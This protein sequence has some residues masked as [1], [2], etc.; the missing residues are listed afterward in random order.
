M[1]RQ[2]PYLGPNPEFCPLYI[3]RWP[4]ENNQHTRSAPNFFIFLKENEHFCHGEIGRSWDVLQKCLVCEGRD[5]TEQL[6]TIDDGEGGSEKK[7]PNCPHT[8]MV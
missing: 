6:V 4:R 2:S 1:S 8:G 5:S 7:L 3:A